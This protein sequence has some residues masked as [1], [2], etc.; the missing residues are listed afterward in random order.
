[1]QTSAYGVLL[2][3]ISSQKQICSAQSQEEYIRCKSTSGE[4]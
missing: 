2:V 4:V 3:E 1:M